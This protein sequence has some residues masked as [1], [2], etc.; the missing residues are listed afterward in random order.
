[1]VTTL[2]IID[3]ALLIG[4]L[5]FS[6]IKFGAQAKKEAKEE[7]AVKPVDYKNG[8]TAEEF[9]KELALARAKLNEEAGKEVVAAAKE[10]EVAP[11][12][13]VSEPVA[14]PVAVVEK[15]VEVPVAPVAAEET[16][17][18]TE[19]E[20]EEDDR[21]VIRRIPFCE[22]MMGMDAKTQEYYD[23]IHNEFRSY[24]KINPRISAKGV[25]YRLG[26]VLV[27]KI[28][29]RGKT[30]KLHLAL[31]IADFEPNV[32]FQKDMSDVKAYAEV[33]FTVKVKSDRGLKN[34]IKLVTAL[35]E[36]KEIV[37]KTRFETINS[38]EELKPLLPV[39][40]E[41]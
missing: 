5:V 3:A 25:S 20:D 39:I 4:L 23:T 38:I 9:A 6:L 28:T 36:Q 41:E 1:M 8:I 13:V 17:V 12:P 37:R 26:R 7:S 19:V 2:L 15:I 16:L 29:L 27:A 32:Y 24:R 40:E 11:A 31:N 18:I 21:E 22:K 10:T 34:A 14:E 33:P 30:M 35:A